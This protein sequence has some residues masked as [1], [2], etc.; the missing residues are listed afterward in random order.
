MIKALRHLFI[1]ATAVI[2]VLKEPSALADDATT[3]DEVNLPTDQIAKLRGFE[4]ENHY[5]NTE[6]GYQINLVRILP[7]KK[8][9][10]RPV[11]FNHGSTQSSTYFVTNS[12]NARPKNFADLDAGSMSQNDLEHLLAQEPVAKSLPFLLACFGHENWMINQRGTEFSLGKSGSTPTESLDKLTS[13]LEATSS[14]RQSDSPSLLDSIL[15][16]FFNLFKPQLNLAS[17]PNT[18]DTRYWNF[19]LDEL[20]KYDLPAILLYVLNHTSCDKVAYVGHSF[21]NGVM[22]MLQSE[23]PQWAD[24]VEP[25][26]AWSPDFYLG[27]TTSILAPLLLTLQPA[28]AATSTPFPPTPI[29]PLTRTLLANLCETKLAQETVCLLVEELQFG[30]SGDQEE[31]VSGTNLGMM[32]TQ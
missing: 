26:L 30:F 24:K 19:S 8:T 7:V 27:H 15:G 2:L 23:Q 12:V 11:I 17:I 4:A 22:F 18:L 28:L 6:G 31:T 10:K 3:N 20:A 29:D 16:G 5:V 21:G 32:I 13:G 25:F 9:N 1:V 14:G